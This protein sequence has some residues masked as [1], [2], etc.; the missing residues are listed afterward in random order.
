MTSLSP[1]VYSAWPTGGQQW[2]AAECD[3]GD[4]RW[5]VV[6]LDT[7]YRHERRDESGRYAGVRRETLLNGVSQKTSLSFITAVLLAQLAF[8]AL[9]L[10][11]AWQEG[12]PACKN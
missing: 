5:F 8:S 9:T 12:H 3:V 7:E 6:V 4:C 1:C 2:T 10:L 11:V